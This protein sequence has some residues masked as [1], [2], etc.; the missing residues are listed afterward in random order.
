V[1]PGA[2]VPVDGKVVFGHSMCDE[3]LITG[4][5]MPVAKKKGNRHLLACVIKS[6][7]HINHKLKLL[8]NLRNI[9]RNLKVHY[10]AYKSSSLVPILINPVN[11]TPSYLSNIHFNIIHPPTS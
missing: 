5:S 3:S 9:L 8:K 1:V 4:E 11:T 6:N 10:R 7:F 2:K